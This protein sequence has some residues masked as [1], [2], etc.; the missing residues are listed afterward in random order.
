MRM[1]LVA[2]RRGHDAVMCSAQHIY[3]D[4]AHTDGVDDWGAAWAAFVAF[5]DV[6]NCKPVPKG[7]ENVAHKIVGVE[8]CFCGEFTTH[9]VEM[10][11]VLAPRTLGLA[12]KPWDKT[13]GADGVALRAL[14]QAYAGL[15]DRIGW[16]RQ[17]G[18]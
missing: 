11:G 4:M 15:F 12:N 6:V 1:G 13:D 5:E 9:D 8:G 7:A 18:A 3:F 14:A 10:E 17:K 16:Q 2:A